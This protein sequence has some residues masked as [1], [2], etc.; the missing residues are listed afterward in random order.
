[1]I[2]QENVNEIKE[3]DN[4]E[5]ILYVSPKRESEDEIDTKGYITRQSQKQQ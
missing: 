1:M 3:I 2:K 4:R 5:I